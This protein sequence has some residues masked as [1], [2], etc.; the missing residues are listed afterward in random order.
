MGVLEQLESTGN[1]PHLIKEL[2]A[3]L[4]NKLKVV[5]RYLPLLMAVSSGLCS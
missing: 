4:G 2:A 3:V 5:Q 1:R